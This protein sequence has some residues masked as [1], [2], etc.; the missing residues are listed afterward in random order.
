MCELGEHVGT[1]AQGQGKPCSSQIWRSGPPSFYP[2]FGTAKKEKERLAGFLE[3]SRNLLVPI[4][5]TPDLLRHSFRRTVLSLQ[6]LWTHRAMYQDD[7]CRFGYTLFHIMLQK[8]TMTVTNHYILHS[9]DKLQLATH[10]QH[11]VFHSPCYVSC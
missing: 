10:M 1:R 11:V 4:Y 9:T 6:L 8:T 2:K 3:S 5:C 7:I